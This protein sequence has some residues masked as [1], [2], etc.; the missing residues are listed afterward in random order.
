MRRFLTY[1]GV[2]AI[3]G[4]TTPLVFVLVKL[5]LKPNL[6]PIV[7]FSLEGPN[8]LL[9]IPIYITFL[10]ILM[11]LP[12]VYAFEI[13]FKKLLYRFGFVKRIVVSNLIACFVWI[14]L[15]DVK[16]VSW[17]FFLDNDLPSV[18]IILFSITLAAIIINW[19]IYGIQTLSEGFR[20]PEKIRIILREYF[21]R[22]EKI[23][24]ILRSIRTLLACFH[25]LFK[26]VLFK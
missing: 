15:L 22:S 14:F 19:L 4:V 11:F 24:M 1:V 9:L 2:Y 13:I 5:V 3:A 20:D 21:R 12:F 18:A 25:S 10:Y 8:S 23:K 26:K 6:H 16:K 7:S 17:E